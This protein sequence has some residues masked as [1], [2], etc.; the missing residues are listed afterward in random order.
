MLGSS[1]KAWMKCLIYYTLS[2]FLYQ[3]Q[4]FLAL[5]IP[6]VSNS[7]KVQK[8]LKAVPILCLT[9]PVTPALSFRRPEAVCSGSASTWQKWYLVQCGFSPE[10]PQSIFWLMLLWEKT[11]H[12]LWFDRSSK[13]KQINK[14]LFCFYGGNA[15]KPWKYYLF[16]SPYYVWLR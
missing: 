8:R 12:I 7:E 14:L 1:S 16:L 9:F 10:W 5:S 13:T 15:F 6:L 4:N 3:P 2:I 11:V